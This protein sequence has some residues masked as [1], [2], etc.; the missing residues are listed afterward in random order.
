VRSS[1]EELKYAISGFTNGKDNHPRPFLRHKT[2]DQIRD[3]IT[4]FCMCD[5]YGRA[6]ERRELVK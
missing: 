2:T 4:R 3:F 5:I 1:T 6:P